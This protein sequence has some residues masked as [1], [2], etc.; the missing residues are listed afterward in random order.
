MKKKRLKK[1]RNL[2]KGSFSYFFLLFLMGKNWLPYIMYLYT[3][4]S[5][6]FRQR[7]GVSNDCPG[8]GAS[9]SSLSIFGFSSQKLA[10]LFGFLENGR[11]IHASVA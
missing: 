8:Y 7:S 9:L 4:E 6:H 2:K 10:P 11:L 3:V 1:E 5:V